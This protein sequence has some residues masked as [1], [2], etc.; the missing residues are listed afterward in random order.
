MKDKKRLYCNGLIIL[1]IFAFVYLQQVQTQFVSKEPTDSKFDFSNYIINSDPK[2]VIEKKLSLYLSSDFNIIEF[3]PENEY[4]E[5]GAKIKLPSNKCDEIIEQLDLFFS[6]KTDLNNK[7]IPPGFINVHK[8]WDLDNKNIEIFY[9][10]YIGINEYAPFSY[11]V[12]V[13]IT[14]EKDEYRYMYISY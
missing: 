3:D 10:R 6:G 7:S 13:F 12:Y 2:T 14:F 11:S 9:H 1:I 4:G 8:W 5:F